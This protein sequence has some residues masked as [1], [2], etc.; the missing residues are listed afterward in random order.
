MRI[1]LK[2]ATEDGTERI[3]HKFLLFPKWMGMEI[4]WLEVAKW[5]EVWYNN[6]EYCGWC[7]VG[8][9]LN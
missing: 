4:R 6:G 9:F 8:N 7:A 3:R 2:P 5:K 1:R